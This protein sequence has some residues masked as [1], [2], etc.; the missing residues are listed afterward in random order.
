VSEYKGLLVLPPR[1]YEIVKRADTGLLDL[2]M[3]P[4]AGTTVVIV[5]Q[6]RQFGD[7]IVN[8]FTAPFNI[9]LIHCNTLITR[10]NSV[11]DDIK[12]MNSRTSIIGAIPS[13][14]GRRPEPAPDPIRG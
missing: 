14:S 9:I 6:S 10:T 12:D 7:D 8:A 3:I 1:H 11:I 4:R 5:Y 2:S 13:P